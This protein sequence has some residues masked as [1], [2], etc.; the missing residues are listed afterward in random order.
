LQAG[1]AATGLQTLTYDGAEES[2]AS[3]R[4]AS[5]ECRLQNVLPSVIGTRPPQHHLLRRVVSAKVLT[6]AS[7]SWFMP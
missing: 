7:A 6:S 3:R 4:V 2:A 1:D 5:A